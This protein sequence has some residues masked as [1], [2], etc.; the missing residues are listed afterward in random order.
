M[1]L[2]EPR[3]AIGAVRSRRSGRMACG[4]RAAD[5]GSAQNP[6]VTA[7]TMPACLASRGT[8]SFFVQTR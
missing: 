7:A 8:E 2:R 5:H 1:S 6:L 3:Q 4:T